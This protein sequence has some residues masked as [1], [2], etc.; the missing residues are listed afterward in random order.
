[1]PPPGD[2]RNCLVALADEESL[3]AELFQYRFNGSDLEGHSFGNLFIAALTQM[4][5][6]FGKAIRLANKIIAVRGRV[7]PATLDH[8]TLEAE[9]EDG[10]K[11]TGEKRISRSGRRI[12]RVSLRPRPGRV[13]ED[14]KDSVAQADILVFGPGSLFTS[15]LPPL[16]NEGMCD[17]ILQSGAVKVYVCNVMTQPGETDGFTAADHVEAILDHTDRALFDRVVVNTAMPPRALLEKYAREGAYPVKIDEER[18][19]SAGM[20]LIEGD[21]ISTDDYVRHDPDKLAR[22]LLG[23]RIIE[24]AAKP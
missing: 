3:I 15:V 19:R 18:I 24:V 1:M 10:T 16:L 12:R 14:E 17:C 8:V 9:H 4:T 23:A 21:V 13:Q 5:G 11:T 22:A 7:L 20:R 6:D 2:I